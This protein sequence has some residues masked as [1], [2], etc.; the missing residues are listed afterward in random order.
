MFIQEE[1]VPESF[2]TFDVDYTPK[3]GLPYFLAQIGLLARVLY[4]DSTMFRLEEPTINLYTLLLIFETSLFQMTFNLML[5]FIMTPF[6]PVSAVLLT[7][8]FLVTL[9]AFSYTEG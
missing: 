2:N 1:D 7:L 5:N 9:V 6:I 4:L 8:I 3:E